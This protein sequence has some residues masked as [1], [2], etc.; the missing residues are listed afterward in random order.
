MGDL[1][2]WDSSVA[3]DRAI[4]QQLAELPFAFEVIDGLDLPRSASGAERLVIG[5]GG[6]YLVDSRSTTGRLNLNKG[7]LWTGRHSLRREL[8][9]TR[10]AAK[11]IELV[12]GAPVM[13]VLCFAQAMLPQPRQLIEGV[14][15]CDCESLHSVLQE[16]HDPLTPDEVHALRVDFVAPTRD[17]EAA[18]PIITPDMTAEMVGDTN[19][20]ITISTTPASVRD[21]QPRVARPYVRHKRDRNERRRTAVVM[22][23]VLLAC[24]AA[25]VV[26]LKIKQQQQSPAAVV[27]NQAAPSGT[28]FSPITAAPTTTAPPIELLAAPEKTIAYWGCLHKGDGWSVLPVWPGDPNSRTQGVGDKAIKYQFSWLSAFGW[29]DWGTMVVAN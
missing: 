21:A 11:Q 1:G 19:K 27:A 9:A 26:A 2:R 25:V 12:L 16:V 6:S 14:I 7:T 28:P 13:P 18:I 23:V 5:P 17:T 24:A 20:T 3:G 15:V 10:D 22:V 8:E 4:A 29:I